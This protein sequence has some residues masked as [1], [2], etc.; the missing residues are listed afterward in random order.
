[1]LR[2]PERTWPLHGASN[3]RDLGGYPS[4]DGR[5]VRWRRLFRSDHLAALSDDDRR[6]LAELG[7]ARAFDFRGATERAAQPYELPG[8]ARHP[9]VIEPTV[10]QRMHDLARAGRRLDGPTV[11]GLMQDLYRLLID[12][13]SARYAEL[14]EHLLD[15][16]APVVFHCTA[17]KDRT[18]VAAALILLSLGVPRD[19]IMQDYLLTNELYRP[20]PLPATETP[21]EALE[22]LWRVEPG[23]LE[24]ALAQIDERHGGVET[25]LRERLRLSPAARDALA[26][27]YLAGG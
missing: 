16:E 4:E 10:V 13:Q 5:H 19:W 18:G 26:R 27:R 6:R 21:R 7:L 14:F 22:V 17:G 20:P 1:M 24:A 9:L 2:H 3:F 12:E 25:Y 23:F 15:V 8:V 11:R